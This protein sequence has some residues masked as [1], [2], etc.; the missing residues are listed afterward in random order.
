MVNLQNSLNAN[1]TSTSHH[2]QSHDGDG[3]H[4]KGSSVSL[5]FSIF[6]N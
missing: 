3:H 6:N 4:R 2:K 1:V 5:A